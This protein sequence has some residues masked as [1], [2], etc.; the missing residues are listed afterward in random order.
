[1]RMPLGR[2]LSGCPVTI[3]RLRDEGSLSGSIPSP[4]KE[5]VL[6]PWLTRPLKDKRG[7]TDRTSGKVFE[8]RQ[9]WGFFRQ[10]KGQRVRPAFLVVTRPRHLDVAELADGASS[11]FAQ[12]THSM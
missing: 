9:C 11:R 4:I 1:M 6:S 10:Q 2:P 5:T 8:L 7:A 12:N 3:S